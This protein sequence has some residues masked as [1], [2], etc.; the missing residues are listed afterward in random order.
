M[1]ASA[2]G[3]A[4]LGTILGV[5]AHPDDEA[6][7]SGGLMALARDAGSRVVCWP[8]PAA[9]WAHWTRLPGHRTGWPQSGP[10]SWRAAWRSSG[11]TST[12]GLATAT[13]TV[14]GSVFRTQSDGCAP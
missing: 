5:W 8:R 13:A 11:S 1:I 9:N 6:Y 14:R 2:A 12:T 3:V 10:A 7:L 4:A